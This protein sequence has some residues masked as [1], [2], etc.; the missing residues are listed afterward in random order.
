MCSQ[1]PCLPSPFSPAF[2]NAHTQAQIVSR[3]I[4]QGQGF[5]DLEDDYHR[6]N[7]NAEFPIRR[8]GGGDI[9]N[10]GGFPMTGFAGVG[11]ARG[12]KRSKDFCAFLARRGDEEH[13]EPAR[14]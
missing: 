3:T 12:E 2:S 5:F 14:L 10:G 8:I 9:G 6:S 7:A 4:E 13:V 11:S 1:S